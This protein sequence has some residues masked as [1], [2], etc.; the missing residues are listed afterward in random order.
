MLNIKKVYLSGTNTAW[1]SYGYDFGNNAWADHGDQWV[2]E[3]DRVGPKLRETKRSCQVLV[4]VYICQVA[5][6][7]ELSYDDTNTNTSTSTNC[8]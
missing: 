5:Q 8:Q 6:A 4:K 1:I 2:A 7:E 3:L